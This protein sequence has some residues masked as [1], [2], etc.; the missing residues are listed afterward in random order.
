MFKWLMTLLN[1]GSKEPTAADELTIELTKG[2][3][4]SMRD[5]LDLYCRLA[6]RREAVW[7]SRCAKITTEAGFA[8]QAWAVRRELIAIK[9]RQL[10]F[11]N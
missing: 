10:D 4:M 5:F 11:R 2:S 3:K 6:R 8:H 9:M 1:W 7:E